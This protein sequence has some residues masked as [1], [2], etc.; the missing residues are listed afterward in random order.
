MPISI[1]EET[2]TTISQTKDKTIKERIEEEVAKTSVL[3]YMKGSAQA[4]MC[5]FSAFVCGVLRQLGVSFETRDVLQDNAL[6]EGIKAFSN[7]PTLPQLYIKGTFVGGCDIV[8]AQYE[9][10]ALKKLFQ[11][12]SIL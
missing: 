6:R 10:G 9:S 1:S 8:K 11:E 3:L 7:W 2:L 5:G 4:P 12:K